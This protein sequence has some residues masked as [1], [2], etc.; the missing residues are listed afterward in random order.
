MFR[1]ILM[2]LALILVGFTTAA[3]A[4]TFYFAAIPDQD[5]TRLRSRFDKVANYLVE[6]LQVDV[7]YIPVKSY[8]V[9]LP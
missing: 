3:Q 7:K 4:D 8:R 5:E 1:K 2:T 6:Q 9:R